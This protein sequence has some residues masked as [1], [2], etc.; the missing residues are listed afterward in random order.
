MNAFTNKVTIN[1]YQTDGELANLTFAVKDNI[2][3]ANIITGNGNPCWGDTHAKSIVNAVCVEQLLSA[4]AT[5]IGKTQQDELAYSLI[6]SND[7]YGNLVNCKA[8][9]RVIGGSSSGSAS[10]VASELVDFSLGSDTGG[11]VRVPASNC[12]LWGYRPSHGLVSYAGVTSLAP[13]FDT[14]GVLAN[15]AAMLTKVISTLLAGDAIA[16]SELPTICLLDDVTT[17]CA[18]PLVAAINNIQTKLA[19]YF[20]I[21]TITLSD[22]THM[23]SH[24]LKLFEIAAPLM[25]ME[26]WNT[27]GAWFKQHKSDL[28]SGLVAGLENHAEQ[29]KRSDILNHLSQAQLFRNN[30]QSYLHNKNKILCFPT[31]VDLAPKLT[32]ITPEFLSTGDYYPRTMG[33]TAISGL[34]ACPEITVPLMQVDEV[35][36]GL[37]FIAPYGEDLALSETLMTIEKKLFKAV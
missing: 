20:T 27:L 8:V 35:P 28:S 18:Q 19:R 36:I 11:S 14:V 1:P 10:V 25:S 16:K 7:F 21:E 4:A 33:V 2:D 32:D 24:P 23:D 22:A 5:C 15:N 30:L 17:M 37:S 9:D 34:S 26:I 12:G 31:T 3:I 29:A 13:S 6:G